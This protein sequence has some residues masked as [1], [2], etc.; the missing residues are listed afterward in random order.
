MVQFLQEVFRVRRIHETCSTFDHAS[1]RSASALVVRAEIK[2]QTVEYKDGDAT[3][4]GFLAYDDAV[5]GKRPGIVVC[6]EWWGLID[7]PNRAPSNSPS[8]ATSPSPPTS[9]A[10][11]TR[12]WTQSRRQKAG[13]AKKADL[14]AKRGQ[15]A[16]EQLK[17]DPHV[18]PRKTAAIGYCF[19]G[20][21]VLEMARR[22]GGPA[23]RRQLPLARS[24][25]SSRRKP[26]R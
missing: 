14:P 10:R 23:R 11:G 7:Y 20:H 24:T 4:K 1:L 26:E 18:D 3:L 16:L 2:T 21:T 12:P 19:G 5:E 17:K 6:P 25:R 15:L 9:M 22:G 13:E 8:W